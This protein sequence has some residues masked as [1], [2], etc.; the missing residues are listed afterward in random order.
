MTEPFM[1]M[2]EVRGHISTMKARYVARHKWRA[3]GGGQEGVRAGVWR[4]AGAE[5]AGVLLMQAQC[6]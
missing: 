1:G 4:G 2:S 3:G 5:H 6:K